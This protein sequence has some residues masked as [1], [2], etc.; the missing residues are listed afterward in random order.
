M[1]PLTTTVEDFLYVLRPY[2]GAENITILADQFFYEDDRLIATIQDL[3]DEKNRTNAPPFLLAALGKIRLSLEV[4]KAESKN[5]KTFTH[6][7]GN[8]VVD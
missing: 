7:T 5:M 6:C 8:R 2:L 3:L 4:E 1:P